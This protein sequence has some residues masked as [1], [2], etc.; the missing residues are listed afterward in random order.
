MASF[1]L[2]PVDCVSVVCVI[3]FLLRTGTVALTL[4]VFVVRR[5]FNHS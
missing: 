5:K 3:H 2:C 1:G 4:I